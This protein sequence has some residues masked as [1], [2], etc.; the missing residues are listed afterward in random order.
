MHYGSNSW[1]GR[2]GF[3]A[4]VTCAQR[5]CSNRSKSEL[6]QELV[7]ITVFDIGC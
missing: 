1:N 3:A 7:I 4:H 2:M 5:R 6:Q